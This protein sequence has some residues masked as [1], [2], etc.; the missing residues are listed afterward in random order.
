[1]AASWQEILP[2]EEVRVEARLLLCTYPLRAAESLQ[3]AAAIIWCSKRPQG[4]IFIC[5][6]VRLREAAANAGFTV[7]KP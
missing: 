2:N 7:L 4:R 6:E 3:L 1:M 5:S